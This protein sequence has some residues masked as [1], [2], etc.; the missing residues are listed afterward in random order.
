MRKP[1]LP[2]LCKKAYKQGRRLVAPLVGFPGV[3][4]TGTT[5]KLAQQNYG[6][7]YK[8]VKTLATTF[9]PDLALPLM[10]LSV[11]AN[12]VGRYTVFPENDSATVPKAK[13]H[14]DML[15]GLTDIHVSFDSRLISY[16]ETMKLMSL[17]L[18]KDIVKG[19]YV[20]GPYTLAAL[21][22]GADDAA[23][24][25][26]TEP[27]L[28]ER[29]CEFATAKIQEY[30]RQLIAAGAELICILEP[31]SVMLGAKH[32]ER[33]SA[34]YVRHITRSCR[35]SG[36]NTVYHVCGN[37]MH[38][39]EIMAQAGVS[40]ISLDSADVGIDLPEAARRAGE[41][42]VV[43]GNINPTGAILRGTPEQVRGEVDALLEAMEPYPNFL[44]STGCDLPQ[45]TPLDN[46]HAFMEAGRA[47]HIGQGKTKPSAHKSR[48]QTCLL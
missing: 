16:V 26:V 38:L 18:P 25:T 31:T 28:L 21:I 30:T 13:F 5:I 10:D 20:A 4:M 1:A 27:A 35:Y 12:A 15:D 39:T 2:E 7:H 41:D 42:V 40:G 44:L 23:L 36:V 46:I 11:E 24:A 14:P 37:T 33:F 6:E 29:L 32:F 48:K 3:E 19:A 47:W 43:I 9:K 34:Q 45:E 17:G 8:A 22:M